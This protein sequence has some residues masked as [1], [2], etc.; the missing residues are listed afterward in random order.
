[1]ILYYRFLDLLY[2]FTKCLRNMSV[3]WNKQERDIAYSLYL[4]E[5]NNRKVDNDNK[6][7][8]KEKIKKNNQ[9]G[10]NCSHRN[11]LNNYDSIDFTIHF[12]LFLMAL[13]FILIIILAI[14]K[15]PI[16]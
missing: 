2:Y 5:K 10:Y 13:P 11:W 6:Q 8:Q 7:I 12:I 14:L 4:L 16:K 15:I 9:W 3:L 1:M